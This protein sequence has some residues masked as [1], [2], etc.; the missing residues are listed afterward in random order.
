MAYFRLSCKHFGLNVEMNF[1]PYRIAYNKITKRDLQTQISFTFNFIDEAKLKFYNNKRKP[2][3]KH[4][5]DKLSVRR[6]GDKIRQNKGK[7]KNGVFPRR[8]KNNRGAQRKRAHKVSLRRGRDNGL[9][10]ISGVLLFP[11][12]RARQRK[13]GYQSTSKHSASGLCGGRGRAVRVRRMGK[14]NVKQLQQRKNRR[15]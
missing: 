11:K 2:A 3:Q 4:W 7:R 10:G 14:R 5:R 8:R 12:R 1:D 9:Q 15:R 13:V 6:A